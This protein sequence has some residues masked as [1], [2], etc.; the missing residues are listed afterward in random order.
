[1]RAEGEVDK[2]ENYKVVVVPVFEVAPTCYQW[3]STLKTSRDPPPRDKMFLSFS[4]PTS[5]LP[6]AHQP[7]LDGDGDAIM[8][9]QEQQQQQQES[10][11]PAPAV[12][13]VDGCVTT[14]K[15][16]LVCHSKI[17]FFLKRGFCSTSLL[18][19]M[20]L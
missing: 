3:I 6:V 18:L 1:M 13:D 20:N 8:V 9:A 2:E 19:K 16:R 4:L 7:A 5:L 12:C 11:P 17:S 10:I 14:R 15:Y